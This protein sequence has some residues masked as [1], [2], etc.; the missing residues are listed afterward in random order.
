M[1]PNKCTVRRATLEDLQTLRGMWL[2][3]QLP[4]TELEKHLTEFQVVSRADGVLAGCLAIRIQAGQGMLHSDA[5]HNPEGERELLPMLWERMHILTKN[6]GLFRVWTKSTS[7]FWATIGFRTPEA[8]ELERLPKEFHDQ[9][10]HWQILN[11]RDENL[12]AGNLDKEFELF[13]MQQRADS[14][15]MIKQAKVLKWVAF[16][17]AA[18]FF[19]GALLLVLSWI[20]RSGKL[21]K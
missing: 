17:I 10:A 16:G 4:A 9:A 12:L 3:S 20:R 18:A 15:R 7:P 13:Q 8:K 14:E 21:K 1:D 5:F 11:L 6:H 2:T 19:G